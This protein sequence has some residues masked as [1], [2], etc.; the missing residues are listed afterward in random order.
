MMRGCLVFFV[1]VRGL[2]GSEVFWLLEW[3]GRAQLGGSGMW[4]PGF[5][6]VKEG[7]ARDGVVWYGLSG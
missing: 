7:R 1:V 5:A 3:I 6:V 4:R 2:L